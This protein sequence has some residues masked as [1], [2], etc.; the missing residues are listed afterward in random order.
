MSAPFGGGDISNLSTSYQVTNA[1]EKNLESRHPHL[2][3]RGEGGGRREGEGEGGRGEGGTGKGRRMLG[4]VGNAQTCLRIHCAFYCLGLPASAKVVLAGSSGWKTSL[5]QHTT[6]FKLS[7]R[8]FGRCAQY[9]QANISG[10]FLIVWNSTS[11][12]S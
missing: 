1:S 2:E 4:K 7:R 5:V 10:H 9:G 12:I 11:T 8:I 3:Q 6:G